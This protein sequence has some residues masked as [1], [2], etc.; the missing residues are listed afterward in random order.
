MRES[1]RREQSENELHEPILLMGQLQLQHRRL[2]RR[3]TRTHRRFN[4]DTVNN[5]DD[6]KQQAEDTTR[7]QMHPRNRSR[8]ITR[9]TTTT[10]R[11]QSERLYD[12]KFEPQIRDRV[13]IINPRNGQHPWGTVQ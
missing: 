6:Q 13:R 11:R 9:R 5:Q 3:L 12:K 2:E 10:V 1:N 7:E 8:H 4:D